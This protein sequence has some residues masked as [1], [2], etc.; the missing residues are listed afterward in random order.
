VNPG[1][2][3]L[4]DDAVIR[5]T[6]DG[7]DQLSFSK[8]IAD[9]MYFAEQQNYLTGGVVQAQ[10]QLCWVLSTGIGTTP[11]K[12][13]PLVEFQR[14]PTGLRFF[15]WGPLPSTL[16]WTAAGCCDAI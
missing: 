16:P 12:P 5:D 11:P 14:N 13:P 15:L 9:K 6:I 1:Y 8:S 7:C 2:G 4:R 3:A 10:L